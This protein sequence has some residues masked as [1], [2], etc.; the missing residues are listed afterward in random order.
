ML[1]E[2]LMLIGPWLT[3]WEDW[4]KLE[5]LNKATHEWS[6]FEDAAI[7]LFGLWQE[8]T[9]SLNE[10]QWQMLYNYDTDFPGFE[11][12]FYNPVPFLGDILKKSAYEQREQ[13][14]GILYRSFLELS[15]LSEK[16][17]ENAF[18]EGNR[19]RR[20]PLPILGVNQ[21][22]LINCEDTDSLGMNCIPPYYF[23]KFAVPK[24][25]KIVLVDHNRKPNKY[26]KGWIAET[27]HAV[28]RAAALG[29]SGLI[30]YNNNGRVAEQVLKSFVCA[31]EEQKEGEFESPLE[32]L[33][34]PIREGFRDID[35]YYARCMDIHLHR[36]RHQFALGKLRNLKFLNMGCVETE[37]GAEDLGLMEVP[38]VCPNLKVLELGGYSG[39]AYLHDIQWP[40]N[41]Y[42]GPHNCLNFD[43][44][45]HV[46]VG[47][48]FPRV[49]GIH[50][51]DYAD[52][53]AF[54]NSL[55]EGLFPSLRVLICRCL[56]IPLRMAG[57]LTIGC[58]ALR[59]LQIDGSDL[60][61]HT[62][63]HGL[64]KRLFVLIVYR[65]GNGS[66]ILETGL[67]P[68]GCELRVLTIGYSGPFH[69]I[70]LCLEKILNVIDI[71]LPKLEWLNVAVN[72]QRH[73]LSEL[74][75]PDNLKRQ[76]R[77]KSIVLSFIILR[78]RETF[79]EEF[80][81]HILI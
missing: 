77:Q 51:G 70:P 40:D 10:M 12:L 1:K 46:R 29:L 36:L 15:D 80:I 24:G 57:A 53:E 23:L 72:P 35:G 8:C 38:Y 49:T 32:I 75:L 27:Y 79:R 28:G 66:L 31:L 73:R 4:R 2:V 39:N 61:R 74:E 45:G 34:I 7:C 64:L 56:I 54:L 60:V 30:V 42:Y 6:H 76:F 33:S 65:K 16:I 69:D 11:C 22:L 18:R 48:T 81:E 41:V 5:R 43:N 17:V 67:F 9:T 25:L 47:K 58:P 20:D 21:W 26:S 19:I 13:N 68:V 52:S 59:F 62:Y 78:D 44:L 37:N 71:C 14:R 50:L 3:T 63:W 55:N